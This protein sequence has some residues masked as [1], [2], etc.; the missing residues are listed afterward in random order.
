MGLVDEVESDAER[1]DAKEDS[2]GEA[3]ARQKGLH[4]RRGSLYPDTPPYP[5]RVPPCS[6]GQTPGAAFHMGVGQRRSARKTYVRK[7]PR[8]RVETQAEPNTQPKYEPVQLGSGEASHVDGPEIPAQGDDKMEID[9]EPEGRVGFNAGR[10]SSSATRRKHHTR[11]RSALAQEAPMPPEVAP[12]NPPEPLRPSEA[13]DRNHFRVNISKERKKPVRNRRNLSLN[14]PPTTHAGFSENVSGTNKQGAPPIPVNTAAT[15]QQP[16]LAENAP[17]PFTRPVE[18]QPNG[19]SPSG[20]CIGKVAAEKSRQARMSATASLMELAKQKEERAERCDNMRLEA[21]VLLEV[22]NPEQARKVIDEALGIHQNDVESL[23]LRSTIHMETKNFLGAIHDCRKIVGLNAHYEKATLRLARLYRIVGCFRRA[24]DCLQTLLAPPIDQA[25]AGRVLAENSALGEQH[26][27]QEIKQL[28]AD[29]CKEMCSE[30]GCPN[31]GAKLDRILELC[32]GWPCAQLM[33]VI[34]MFNLGEE[35]VKEDVVEN[36]LRLAACSALFE[37]PG[38]CTSATG[39]IVSRLVLAV[40]THGAFET[41]S[42]LASLFIERFRD[43][44]AKALVEECTKHHLYF[45]KLKLAKDQ[46]NELFKEK[47]YNQAICRYTEALKLDPCHKYYNAILRCNRAAAFLATKQYGN[48]IA[49]CE[50]A[51]ELVPTYTRA[52]VRRARVHIAMC[53]FE[54]A[55]ID[56]EEAYKEKQQECI[57]KEI[58]FVKEQQRKQQREREAKEQER[59]RARSAKYE[60]RQ[61]QQSNFENQNTRNEPSASGD[62]YAIL[63]ISAQANKESIRKAYLK[64]ALKYHP[65]K[66]G[67]HDVMAEERFKKIATAYE[68]LK[69]PT[70]RQSYDAQQSQRFRSYQPFSSYGTYTHRRTPSATTASHHYYYC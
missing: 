33:K 41:A 21:K 22:G 63:G 39:K 47:S 23:F 60:Q 62:F 55:L 38:I 2:E 42:K 16:A 64:L 58:Q 50:K 52:R 45:R 65:D 57:L 53:R 61:H 6:P 56:L 66:A 35:N 54:A 34:H 14:N 68:T 51:L 26:M 69:D 37:D 25:I 49:D 12:R 8:H 4:S 17:S 24:S 59:S 9:E 36:H 32:P 48:A 46:G 27:Q 40:H 20:F 18:L 70:K 1:T 19:S 67:A 5:T 10:P 30:P 29:L 11:A 31:S 3:P 7:S 43:T 44:A 13:L 15:L 28:Y